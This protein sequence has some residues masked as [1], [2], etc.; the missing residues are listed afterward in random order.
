MKHKKHVGEMKAQAA[1]TIRISE[2]AEACGQ[3]TENLPKIDHLCEDSWFTSAETCEEM[4]KR[5]FK[6][7][8][9]VKNCHAGDPRLQLE[10]LMSDWSGRSYLVMVLGNLVV[11][12]YKYNRQ[13]V[14]FLLSTKNFGSTKP[15]TPY[16]A[17]FVDEGKNI[18]TRDVIQPAHISKYFKCFN[19]IDSHNHVR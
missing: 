17:C 19:A 2:E 18:R 4:I 5:G 3:K 16:C 15:G 10:A 13:K 11:T 9:V 6:Y 7:G 8:G 1:C 14:I 12:S